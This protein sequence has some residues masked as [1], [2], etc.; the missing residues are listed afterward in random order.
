MWKELNV[1]KE[2]RST[3]GVNETLLGRKKGKIRPNKIKIKKEGN[4]RRKQRQ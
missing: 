2:G 1:T 3:G 4:K